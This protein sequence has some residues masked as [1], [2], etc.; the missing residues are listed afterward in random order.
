MPTCCWD[1][2]HWCFT[3]LCGA[4]FRSNEKKEN[5]LWGQQL[6]NGLA[7]EIWAF[8]IELIR[9]R[10]VLLD[11]SKNR[12]PA[13]VTLTWVTVSL[14]TV[15]LLSCPYS[16]H[17]CYN[18]LQTIQKLHFICL[19]PALAHELLIE[20]CWCLCQA[21]SKYSRKMLNGYVCEWTKTFQ[22]K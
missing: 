3:Q 8:P 12:G 21:N 9:S 18:T 22:L 14:M 17:F 20:K 19:S 7:R 2:V 1:R 15:S 5:Q 16:T 13:L 10:A 11:C 6:K 4:I